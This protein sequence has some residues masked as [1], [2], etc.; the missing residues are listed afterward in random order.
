MKVTKVVV[1][2]VDFDELGEDDIKN[3]LENANYPNDCIGPIVQEIETVEV[4]WTDE[5]PLN[6]D[7]TSS[8]EFERLFKEN[9]LGEQ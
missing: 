2:I 7:S 1:M 6:M 4:D 5:H 3:T 9:N 8:A